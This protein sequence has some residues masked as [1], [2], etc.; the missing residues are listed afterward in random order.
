MVTNNTSFNGLSPYYDI[1]AGSTAVSPVLPSR[2]AL[3]PDGYYYAATGNYTAPWPIPHINDAEQFTRKSLRCQLDYVR[4]KFGDVL[5]DDEIYENSGRFWRLI[6]L[7]QLVI[8]IDDETQL[9][10]YL[11][12]GSKLDIYE[13][14]LR[15]YPSYLIRGGS[16]YE[17]N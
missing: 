2:A 7:D 9:S 1:T 14:P 3:G 6:D 8:R 15:W 13:E 11:R 4:D 5:T 10:I 16:P 12:Y 17:T